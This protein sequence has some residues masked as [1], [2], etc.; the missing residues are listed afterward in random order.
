MRIEGAGNTDIGVQAAM[1]QGNDAITKSIQSRIQSKEQEIQKLAENDNLSS[2]EKMKKRQEIQKEINEL[3]KQLRQH[4]MDMRRQQ[5][6]ERADSMDKMLGGNDSGASKNGG[7]SQ[8]SMKAM[9]SADSSMKQVRAQESTATKLEGDARNLKAEIRT[10][11]QRG[12]S[13]EDKKEALQDLEERVSNI[14]A[15]EIG[16]LSDAVSEMKEAKEEE[17]AAGGKEDGKTDEKEK[18]SDIADNAGYVKAA[19][20]KTT[21]SNE[22]SSDTAAKKTSDSDG[23]VKDTAQEV[24][25]PVNYTSVDILL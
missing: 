23:A 2:E 16:T 17:A 1:P 4:Q 13:V 8:A 3:N 14:R 9:V 20:I 11:L 6:Q 21:D 25:L 19:D 7:L 22:M 15:S 10:D 5:Q 24:K 12:D 18:A